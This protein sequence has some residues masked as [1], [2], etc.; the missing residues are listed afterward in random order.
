MWRDQLL[1]AVA[2]SKASH[3]L[4]Q[5]LSEYTCFAPV[6]PVTR[7]VSPITR[8]AAPHPAKRSKAKR[9]EINEKIA[10]LLLKLNQTKRNGTNTWI[11]MCQFAHHAKMQ[12]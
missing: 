10:N 8:K 7:V 2:V 6:Y 12:N 3:L 9:L 4:L 1:F 5:T 11:E